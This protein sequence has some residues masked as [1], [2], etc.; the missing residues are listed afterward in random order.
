VG[1]QGFD[2]VLGQEVGWAIKRRQACGD[3][4]PGANVRLVAHGDG[5]AAAGRRLGVGKEESKKGQGSEA[6]K[7]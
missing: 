7:E 5:Y 6:V 4:G 1:E 3:T 2:C